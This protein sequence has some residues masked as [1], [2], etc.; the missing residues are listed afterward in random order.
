MMA[1]PLDQCIEAQLE[2]ISTQEIAGAY[3]ALCGLMLCATAVAYRKRAI[4]RKDDVA[5]RAVARQWVD[6]R[7]GLITFPECCEALNLDS[8]RAAAALKSFAQ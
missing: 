7:E 3:R 5:A 1:D 6:T 2:N 4:L 8:E